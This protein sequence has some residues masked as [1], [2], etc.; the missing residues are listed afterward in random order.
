MNGLLKLRTSILINI[1]SPW[2]EAQG[3]LSDTP[4][5]FRR[6]RKIYDSLSTNMNYDV[7]RRQAIQETLIH[8]L[9]RFQGSLRRHGPYNTLQNQTMRGLGFPECSTQVCEQLYWESGSYYM[10]PHCITPTI[11]IQRGTLQGDTLS[12]FLFT[13]FME[14]LLRW[15]SIGSRG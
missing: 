5:G 4:D 1:G 3:I 8:S 10:T 14:P 9:L 12:P 11:P 7:R 13:I 15:L 6:T 2:A